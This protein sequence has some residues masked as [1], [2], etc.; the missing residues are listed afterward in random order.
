MLLPPSMPENRTPADAR[1]ITAAGPAVPPV[2]IFG[3]IGTRRACVFADNVRLVCVRICHHPSSGRPRIGSGSNKMV[4]IGEH[5]LA[6]T[7]I[8]SCVI[9]ELRRRCAGATDGVVMSVNAGG[10]V[11][12]F[13][14][15][16]RCAWSCCGYSSLG[17]VMEENN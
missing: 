3:I 10:N 11:L 2:F 14:S 6:R 9:E 4:Q 16:T 7:H 5:T 8:C 1:T 12:H 15:S 13:G 17:C